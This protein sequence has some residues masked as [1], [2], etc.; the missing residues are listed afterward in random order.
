M[1]LFLVFVVV[2][3]LVVL[4]WCGGSDW[5]SGMIFVGF[6]VVVVGGMVVFV[7]GVGFWVMFI[8][9]ID[10]VCGLWYIFMVCIFVVGLFVLLFVVLLLWFVVC[11]GVV[12]VLVL[13]V[14]FV[15]VLVLMLILCW[16][17]LF[18]ERICCICEE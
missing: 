4:V 1:W 11:F 5:L 9:C 16:C 3:M 7:I 12:F 15:V 17:E 8:D 2:G 18:G 6:V 10:I 14:G 13:L